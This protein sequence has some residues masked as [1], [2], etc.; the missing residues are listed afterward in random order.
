MVDA[1]T[2]CLWF[3]MQSSLGAEEVALG[4]VGGRVVVLLDEQW[5]GRINW[6]IHHSKQMCEWE[7]DKNYTK[8]T[9]TDVEGG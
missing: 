6:P 3:L 4:D 5:V 1:V 8:C 9:L 7:K 2:H